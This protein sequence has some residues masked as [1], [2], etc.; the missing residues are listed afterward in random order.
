MADELDLLAHTLNRL[1]E[2]ERFA[3]AQA[4][5]PEYAEVLDRRLRENGGEELLE[6]RH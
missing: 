4:I 3:D 5:L 6:A 2:Q 1:I